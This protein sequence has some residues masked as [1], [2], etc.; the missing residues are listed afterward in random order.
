MLSYRHAYHTGNHADVLK[1]WV[2]V[3]ILRYLRRKDKPLC[4]VDSHAAAGGYSLLADEV[5]KRAEYQTG[6]EK[7][8]KR[9]DLP[10]SLK[11]YCQLVA[12]YNDD[13]LTRYPGSPWLASEILTDQDQL[14]LH[15]LHNNEVEKLKKAFRGDRRAKVV[16]GDG[17]Q[18]IISLMP[19][20]Q[21]R[22][23][24]LI[25]PSYEVKSEYTQVVE[26][27][28][29]AHRRF[30]TGVFA[31]WYPV[32]DRERIN[33]LEKSLCNSGIKRIHLYELNIHNEHADYGMTGSGMIVINP[34]WGLQDDM[35][36]A[37]PYLAKVL[38]ENGEGSYRIEELAGE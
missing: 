12:S 31:L 8:W 26:T 36:Q 20:K 2:L 5:Q 1:H 24:V 11:G 23:L 17:Y 6:I 28:I 10:D 9:A 15:E 7:L 27:L 13:E 33:K 30:S 35:Q 37:L 14:W 29:K 19:P 32:V 25:D 18:G 38:G 21:R 22:G 3:S 16:H 4:Y 34:P